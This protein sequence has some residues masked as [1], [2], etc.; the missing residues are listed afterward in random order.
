MSVWQIKL[1][2]FEGPMDLLLFLVQKQEYDIMN[3]PM[4]EITESYLGVIDTIGVENLED[5]GEFLLMAATLISIKA[6][7]MLPRP[8][9][10]DVEEAQDP[11]HELAQRLLL[12]QKTKEEAAELARREAEM[13]ERYEMTRSAAPPLPAPEPEELL[14]PMT[15]YD[16]TRAIEEVIRRKDNQLVHK[17]RLDKVTLDERIRWVLHMLEEVKR[18]GLLRELQNDLDRVIWVVTLLAV[19]EMAKRQRLRVEQNEP[20]SEIFV[21]RVTVPELVAA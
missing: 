20:F 14:V 18:F 9:T 5:A 16:L 4:A 1:P 10:E 21:S 19:L 3:L 12:Y 8:K 6:K 7:M 15:I 13:A 17:V 2:L 11:R